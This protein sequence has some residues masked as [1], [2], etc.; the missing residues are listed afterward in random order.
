[1]K[2]F[3][4]IV[5]GVFYIV[6]AF[7]FQLNAQ[8]KDGNT[9]AIEKYF[10]NSS[11][12]IQPINQNKLEPTKGMSNVTQIGNYN[13]SSI[14]TNSKS[15]HSVIQNGN[16][17]KIEFLSYYSGNNFIN[18]V[19]EQ[20]GNN[21]SIQVIGTNSIAKKLK[22]TQIANNSAILVRNYK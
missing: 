9:I 21:N 18:L 7:H 15:S 16:Q 19:S 13:Y 17:N 12:I 1:M 2:Q 11:L 6:L 14:K 4:K 20:I 3:K 10:Q 8:Q 22:I 5:L